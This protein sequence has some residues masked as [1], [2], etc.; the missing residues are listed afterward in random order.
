[1]LKSRHSE[2]EMIG[3]LTADGAGYTPAI[4]FHQGVGKPIHTYPH[5]NAHFRA[6]KVFNIE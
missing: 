2:A 6:K 3:A 1:M 5:N 4:Y